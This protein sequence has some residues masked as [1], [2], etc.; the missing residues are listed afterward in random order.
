MQLAHNELDT[1]KVPT[2]RT[3][4]AGNGLSGGG[5][6]SADRTFDLDIDSLSPGTVS[7]SSAILISN[8]GV[9][10]KATVDDL[11]SWNLLTTLDTSSGSE[12]ETTAIPAGA[13]RITV[14]LDGVSLSGS[15]QIQI[16]L[17]S[18]TY[19]VSSSGLAVSIAAGSVLSVAW[20]SGPIVV[21]RSA[22]AATLMYGHVD[23]VKHDN[24]TW[25]VV[26]SVTNAIT[27]N[28]T[29]GVVNTPSDG[30]LDRLKISTSGSDTLDGGSV[31]IWV[32]S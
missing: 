32:Y 21:T 1:E 20:T 11:P 23:L 16:E 14:V 19:S 8:G 29:S 12:A 2:T 31:H 15:D 4:T 22:T 26:G 18:T 25:S 10:E 24:N 5:D 3:L 27:K 30:E 9:E 17:G 6:L 13:T 7:G 28:D